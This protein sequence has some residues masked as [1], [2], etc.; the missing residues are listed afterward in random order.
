MCLPLKPAKV[1]LLQTYDYVSSR[2][3]HG[4][5]E[6]DRA[7]RCRVF[8]AW[9]MLQLPQRLDDGSHGDRF[10]CL[11]VMMCASLH[12]AFLIIDQYVHKVFV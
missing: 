8:F 3:W 4:L 9:R 11:P 12:M 6:N 10:V 5:S 2:Q 7:N 1:H